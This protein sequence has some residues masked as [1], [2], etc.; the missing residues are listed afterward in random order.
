[1]GL[2]GNLPLGLFSPSWE[3]LSSHCPDAGHRSAHSLVEPGPFSGRNYYHLIVQV[4]KLRLREGG[5]LPKV[6]WQSQESNSD[7]LTPKP[8]LFPI[9][10]FL[11]YCLLATS[12]N[13]ALSTGVQISVWV[14]AFNYFE[15][16]RWA[17]KNKSK[18]Y[19]HFLFPAFLDG[20]G[21]QGEGGKHYIRVHGWV[22]ILQIIYMIRG[23]YPENIKNSH[24]SI[25]KRQ[26]TQLKED[27]GPE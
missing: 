26:I 5:N 18:L 1:M 4:R 27:K 13:A 15:R 14:S 20:S 7:R 25:I 19:L 2:R 16:S 22:K 12:N 11:C 23:L 3:P 21:G 8:D 6:S 24:N 17:L 10:Y 9:I